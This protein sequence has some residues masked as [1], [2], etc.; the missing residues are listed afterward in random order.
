MIKLKVS[1]RSSTNPNK[2]HSTSYSSSK[3]W[4]FSW[5]CLNPR[6][7]NFMISLRLKIGFTLERNMMALIQFLQDTSILILKRKRWRLCSS[8]SQKVSTRSARRRSLSRLR[9]ATRFK[10]ES[11]VAICTLTISSNSTRLVRLIRLSGV[12]VM[13]SQDSRRNL[14]CKRLLVKLKLLLNSVPLESR[15]DLSL[16]PHKEECSRRVFLMLV[17]EQTLCKTS[18]RENTK[19]ELL[20]KMIWCIESSL[21]YLDCNIK[22]ICNVIFG[23]AFNFNL[24]NI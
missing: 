5:S 8:D 18:P 13:W 1:K 11:E 6:L 9:V 12:M 21:K 10:S 16:H 19:K 7:L 20:K 4:S 14:R 2:S 22:Y 15:K 3:T 17:A 23:L 24:L